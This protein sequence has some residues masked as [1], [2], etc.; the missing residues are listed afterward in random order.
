MESTRCLKTC[1][2]TTQKR[3]RALIFFSLLNG[4]PTNLGK[5]FSSPN[6]MACSSLPKEGTNNRTACS[7]V[8]ENLGT[9]SQTLG[10]CLPAATS[11]K[12]SIGPNM[13]FT[14]PSVVRSTVPVRTAN[15]GTSTR[16]RIGFNGDTFYRSGTIFVNSI[17]SKNYLEDE[18]QETTLRSLRILKYATN[19]TEMWMS[20]RYATIIEC[21]PANAELREVQQYWKA[22][23]TVRYVTRN[24]LYH[25]RILHREGV[26]DSYVHEYYVNLCWVNT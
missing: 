20:N 24:R 16:R 25:Q 7:S 10:S 6:R 23:A 11:G 5:R 14:L 13:E 2:L 22:T 26:L 17:M 19:N 12:R 1:A 8:P 21:F 18:R 4:A 9:P 3:V 15:S